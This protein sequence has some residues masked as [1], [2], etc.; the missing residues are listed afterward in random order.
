[1][2]LHY[3]DYM[4]RERRR[5]ELGECER[6]RLLN[7]VGYSQPILIHEVCRDLINLFLRLIKQR[8]YGQRRLQPCGSMPK[9]VAQ[10][11][12]EGQ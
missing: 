2:N 12:G 10:T 5:E 7:S 4:N 9:A 8:I 3:I 11:E 6:R 1:M